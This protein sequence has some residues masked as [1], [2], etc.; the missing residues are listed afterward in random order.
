MKQPSVS[1]SKT[2]QL[3]RL[4]SAGPLF[5]IAAAL[6]WAFDG[7]LRRQ[8][9][10]LPALTV[11]FYEHVL[12]ALLLGVVQIR[13]IQR[14]FTIK[15]SQRN[16]VF[17]LT[18][19]VAALSGVVGTISFTQA[20][21]MVGFIPFSVVLLVQKLQ[22][23]FAIGAA[24]VLLKESL[25]NHYWRW[26]ILAI[27]AS[28]FVTFPRGTIALSGDIRTLYAAG[29]ALLA[30]AAWG[31]ATVFS[32]QLVAATSSETATLLRFAGTTVLAGLIMVVLGAS[33]GVALSTLPTPTQLGTLTLIA[34]TTG[35]AAIW[36][37]YR[38][39]KTV[40]ASV[41]TILELVFPAAAV[42]IEVVL[43]ETTLDW[44]QYL[45]AIVLVGAIYQLS[46]R[47]R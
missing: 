10:S 26:S 33:G 23:V 21:F 11:I 9:F 31:S 4:S 41:S 28:F 29:L 22:P 2:T 17:W 40:R 37:Y 35:M 32:K 8:L 14:L 36:L 20:L 39:L 13:S 34:G 7:V 18:L 47:T 42:F 3:P 25:P 1:T 24:R 30:A 19:I 12:G 38:G 44:T 43:Y 45:A 6:L 5:V 16:Q 15:S 46:T 27:L